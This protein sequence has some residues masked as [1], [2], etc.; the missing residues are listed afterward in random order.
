MRLRI[1]L[2]ATM[3]VGTLYAALALATGNEQ[4]FYTGVLLACAAF[5]GTGILDL[6]TEHRR[7]RDIMRAYREAVW[8]RRQR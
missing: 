3:V 6:I 5:C 2:L 8:A 7:E 4:D 1:G